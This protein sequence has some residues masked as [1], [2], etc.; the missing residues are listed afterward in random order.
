MSVLDWQAA[1]SIPVFLLVISVTMSIVH[2]FPNPYVVLAGMI[3]MA[4][5]ACAMRV[6]S[7][8]GQH[9]FLC[10]RPTDEQL[11]EAITVGKAFLYHFE[12]AK[13]AHYGR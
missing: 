11:Q 9:L 8:L 7:Y 4:L 1:P 6:I 10:K 3:L 13:E 5:S 2:I 12:L